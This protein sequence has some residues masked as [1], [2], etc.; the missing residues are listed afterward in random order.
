VNVESEGQ[1]EHLFSQAAVPAILTGLYTYS[2]D[3]VAAERILRGVNSS[4][5]V[6]DIFG[7]SASE[8]VQRVA[9]YSSQAY[10]ETLHKMNEVAD[11]AVQAI[12]TEVKPDGTI[13]DVK[14]LLSNQINDILKYLPGALHMGKVVNEEGL[15]DNT[16][17]ME[18]PI[19]S[20]M[21]KIGSAFS[22]PSNEAEVNTKP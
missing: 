1:G 3:D 17:K 2:A 10:D 6:S 18:G 8:V 11:V 12:R 5:W 21:H 20:L 13:M 15:D 14:N 9:T 4:N 16:N 7:N 22:N 19:S